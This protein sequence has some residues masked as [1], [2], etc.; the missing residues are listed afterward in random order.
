MAE[1]N[2]LKV[3][4]VRLV[5]LSQSLPRVSCGNYIL[6]SLCARPRRRGA[7]RYGTT[8]LSPTRIASTDPTLGRKLTSLM[9]DA[10]N[11]VA[12][13]APLA[14]DVPYMSIPEEPRAVFS[15]ESRISTPA[16]R[17]ADANSSLNWRGSGACS[18]I[19]RTLRPDFIKYEA[20]SCRCGAVTWRATPAAI[21]LVSDCASSNANRSRAASTSSAFERSSALDACT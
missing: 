7:G 19:I 11:A 10:A 16:S 1:I 6:D 13:V 15:T 4:P 21:R 18:L 3:A 5:A 20:K 8:G 9:P 2:R 12:S 17:K 14:S